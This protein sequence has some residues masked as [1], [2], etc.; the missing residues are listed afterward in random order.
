MRLQ[1][2]TRYALYAVADLA[3][4]P[5][6]YVSASSIAA[7]HNISTNHLA[8]VLRELG[9][10]RLVESVR[11]SGGG[12]RF[13]ANARRVTLLDIVRLFEEVSEE[14][15]EIADNGE[16]AE[17]GRALARILGEIEELAE[18]TLDSVTIETMLKLVDGESRRGRQ[19]T[20]AQRPGPRS[21]GEHDEKAS[22]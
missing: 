2:A 20:T 3:A 12:Y 9:K 21:G 16:G 7:R 22:K 17:A 19:Q 8:K 4:R 5:G 15:R 11:G 1:K 14:A 18:A 6:S 13:A 10:A